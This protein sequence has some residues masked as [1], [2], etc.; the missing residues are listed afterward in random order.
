MTEHTVTSQQDR[1]GSLDLL[2][3]IAIIAILLINIQSFGYV[4]TSYFNPFVGGEPSGLD[5]A[6]WFFTHTLIDQKFYTIFSMLFGAGIVL[7]A[8]RTEHKGLSPAKYHYRRNIFLLIIGLLHASF[9]WYGD[10]LTMYAFLALFTYFMWRRKVITQWIVGLL[11]VAIV[12]PINLYIANTMPVEMVTYVQQAFQP[13]QE[14][15][16]AEVNGYLG[17]YAA[18]MEQRA[19]FG[20]NKAMVYEMF[21]VLRIFGCMIIGMALLKSGYLNAQW[22]KEQYKKYATYAFVLGLPLVLA[23][24][25]SVYITQYDDAVF[26]RYVLGNLNYVGSFLLSLGYI[27]LINL[28]YLNTGSEGIKSRL[29]AMGQMA[30]TNYLTQSV[31]CTTIFYGFGLGLFGELSRFEMLVV[32]ACLAGLQFWY[33]KIWL[34]KF[35][36]G[37]LEWL[38]RMLSYWQFPKLLRD[39]QHQ[40]VVTKSS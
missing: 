37:P 17:S 29:Q 19:E 4:F 14:A 39:K 20:N 26:T 27:S 22:T 12:V 6:S 13:S 15:I 36:M 32:A 40:E 18:N 23:S 24:A 3:G 25:A 30:F 16:A 35:T 38:L 1:Y 28:W 11:C 7:L 10:I 5:I 9:I 33:S 21:T 34:S 31:V 2:R 8:T